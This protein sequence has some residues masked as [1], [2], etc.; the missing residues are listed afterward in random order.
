MYL[1]VGWALFWEMCVY[2]QKSRVD[3]LSTM[4]Y[5]LFLVSP[6]RFFQR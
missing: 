4:A 5:P 1:L 6:Q 3:Y 2:S